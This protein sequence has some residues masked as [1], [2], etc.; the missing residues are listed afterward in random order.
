MYRWHKDLP[1]L[2][3]RLKEDQL[4]HLRW[5]IRGGGQPTRWNDGGCDCNL[6]TFRKDRVYGCSCY[7]CRRES[8][9]EHHGKMK[10]ATKQW[11]VRLE[12]EKEA[13]YDRTLG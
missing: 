2:E 10:H 9:E 1:L 5:F 6:G 13:Q 4:K 3:R 12:R 8:W 11:Q 7:R